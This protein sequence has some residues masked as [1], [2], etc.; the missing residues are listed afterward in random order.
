MKC[1]GA[2]ESI[3]KMDM[4]ILTSLCLGD[5]AV[6]Q[7]DEADVVT[8]DIPE[9]PLEEDECCACGHAMYSVTFQGLW[10]RQTHPKQ[11]PDA[12]RKLREIRQRHTQPT[13]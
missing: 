7:R 9:T 6:T 11:F 13:F 2:T 4:L 8:A 5:V 12:K 10:S 1:P 3:G